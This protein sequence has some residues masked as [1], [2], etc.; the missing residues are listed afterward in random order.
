MPVMTGYATV[1]LV[2]YFD[3]K[4]TGDE[5][6]G[7]FDY[8]AG[9]AFSDEKD[10]SFMELRNKQTGELV[11]SRTF[12]ATDEASTTVPNY[13]YD[14]KGLKESFDYPDVV[15]SDY[16]VNFNFDFPNKTEP[17]NVILSVWE[18]YLDPNTFEMI[19]FPAT[20][21]TLVSGI[22]L[23]EW[24]EYI[25][26]KPVAELVDIKPQSPQEAIDMG[27]S[28]LNSTVSITDANGKPYLENNQFSL[29]FPNE[30]TTTGEIQRIHAILRKNDVGRD[31]L[32]ATDLVRRFPKK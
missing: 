7:S 31:Q 10:Q 18:S 1:P 24:S 14:G 27:F 2:K 9:L 23:R 19:S 6:F 8:T 20:D 32:V 12:K 26:L 22:K 16:L 28:F 25:R 5:L 15:G 21:V 11:Y 17:V 29:Q 3:G 30:W 4:R 13:L